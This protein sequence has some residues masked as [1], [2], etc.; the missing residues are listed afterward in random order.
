MFQN[1]P[2]VAQVLTKSSIHVDVER[3]A[4]AGEEQDLVAG[5][6]V[7]TEESIFVCNITSSHLPRPTN[8]LHTRDTQL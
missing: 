3:V 7:L 8:W 4:A 2:V 6:D 5:E 1:V